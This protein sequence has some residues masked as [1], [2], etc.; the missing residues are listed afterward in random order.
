MIQEEV[1]MSKYI[2]EDYIGNKRLFLESQVKDMMQD[3][4]NFLIINWQKNKPV[5][6]YP[7]AGC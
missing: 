4:K 6:Q 5:E 3:Y 1:I 7:E 2:P